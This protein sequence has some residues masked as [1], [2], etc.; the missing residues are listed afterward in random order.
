MPRI[1][2]KRERLVDAA[3]TLFHQKGFTNT[4]LADIAQFSEVPL[5]NVYYY[6]KTKE[7]LGSAVIDDRTLEFAEYCDDW[8]EY[9]DPRDRLLNY[10]DL[11]EQNA[12]Q[13]VESGCPVGSLCIELNKGQNELSNKADNMLERQLQWMTEQFEES[14]REDAR[15][16]AVHFI[17][18]LQGG[19]LLANSLHDANILI[20]QVER[21]RGLVEKI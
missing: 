3:K 13:V 10:L 15:K 11:I 20:D 16:L 17:T 6:F 18:S 7:E 2:D 8:Y 14:G 5:G 1:S 4:T 12:K 9:E 19:S 21:L